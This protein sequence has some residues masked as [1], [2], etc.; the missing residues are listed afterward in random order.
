VWTSPDG[1]SW[2]RVPHDEAVFGGEGIQRMN[3][4]AAGGPGLV[5]VGSYLDAAV[6][7]SPDGVSWSRVPHDEAVFGGEGIAEMTGVTAGGPGMVAVGLFAPLGYEKA[8]VWTSPDG[9]GWS[10]VPHDEAVFG[11]EVLQRMNSVT[12]GGP[13]LVAVGWGGQGVGFPVH[14]AVWT[15]P[16]GASWSRVP[17]DEAIFGGAGAMYGVAAGGP[18]LVAVGS[19]ESGG[20]EYAPV[21]TATRKN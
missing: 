15:S 2:S 20:D 21:W 4:V 16:D 5:A 18:G 1:V 7:T 10:R 3:S 8:A 9:V 11:G 17:H 19:Y 13:G 14:A 12:A 6:W